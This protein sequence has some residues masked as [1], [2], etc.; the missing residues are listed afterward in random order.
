MDDKLPS[1]SLYVRSAIWKG[2]RER[3]R[4]RGIL[5]PWCRELQVNT[6]KRIKSRLA[7]ANHARDPAHFM[8]SEILCQTEEFP[9]SAI[10]NKCQFTTC[11]HLHKYLWI[12]FLFE[13]QLT[14]EK[15][16]RNPHDGDRVLPSINAVKATKGKSQYLTLTNDLFNM[17]GNDPKLIPRSTYRKNV[18][19]GIR[20]ITY[21]AHTSFVVSERSEKFVTNVTTAVGH[22]VCLM[23]CH[24][25]ATLMPEK[26]PYLSITVVHLTTGEALLPHKDIQKHRLFR[27][28][29]TSF[30]D[31]T[32]GVLQIEENGTWIDHDSR[33][34]WVVLDARTT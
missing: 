18:G 26:F 4:H 15:Y 14:A 28:I 23:K 7:D 19:E 16:L 5:R 13:E 34:A 20:T 25:L 33:D 10:E 29:T 11:N 1:T 21:G 27:N 2:Q 12:K 6:I 17:Y 3:H 9:W 31:W 30:G 8:I 22:E 32:G 24:K